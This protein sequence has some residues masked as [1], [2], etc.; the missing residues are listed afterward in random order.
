MSTQTQGD[1]E[2]L[3]RER[4]SLIPYT[5]LLG[6]ELESVTPG[7]VTL[8]MDVRADLKRNNGIAHGGAIAS[9]IDSATAFAII[10]QDPGQS[11]VT[12]D[13]TVS[14]LKPLVD[15]RATATARV[16]RSGRRVAVVSAEVFDKGQNLV[17]TALSTYIKD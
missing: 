6:I 10:S 2:S 14:F 17:A 1:L 8:G 12:I 9:L 4:L 11:A 7:L 16:I 13:L 15:G 5:K 3:I